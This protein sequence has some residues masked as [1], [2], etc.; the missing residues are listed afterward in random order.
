MAATERGLGLYPGID[1]N[2]KDGEPDDCQ[3]EHGRKSGYQND[4]YLFLHH[5]S[6]PFTSR[7]KEIECM[8]FF[9]QS[10][11]PHADISGGRPARCVR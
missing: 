1:Q 3:R 11:I 9:P 5:N 8:P 7:I 6:S 2:V 10:G 4:F